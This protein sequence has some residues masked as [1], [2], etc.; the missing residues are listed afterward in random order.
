MRRMSR[1]VEVLL[2]TLLA[3]GAAQ[4]QDRNIALPVAELEHLLTSEP[5]VVVSA[6]ISRPKAKGDITLRAEAAF[7]D[8]PP[9]R[10]KVRKAEP[11]AEA[12]NNVPR[13]DLAAY[14]LQ[15]LFLDPAEYV[16]PPTALR[17]MPL[18]ELRQYSPAVPRT[19]PGAEEALVV[20][21]Y[22][23]NDV[24]VIADV[25]NPSRFESDPVYARHIGQLNVFT[26]LIEHR[27]SNAGNFLI[28]RADA[29]ARVFSIDHGV[30][31]AS[32][33]S[34]RGE[35]WKEMRVKRLPADLVAR[36]RT[37][38][39]ESLETRLAVLAQWEVQDGRFVATELSANFAPNR[40]V[41]RDGP[42]LQMG[43]RRTEIGAIWKLLEKL[44]ARIDRGEITTFEA[45]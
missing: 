19:F 8:Q 25:F 31:F 30:A 12:F 13:Y 24:A 37:I 44:L 2:G 15:K 20:V 34:D 10:V 3:L 36:L 33:D 29:G 32:D 40:G 39:P 6:E 5:M 9:F 45:T 23:L 22:W 38:T 43:L 17:M 21:Q 42:R 41:R 18:D 14:E 1:I 26:Y 7:G 4:A 11:G 28:S 35:L 16:V 27:D